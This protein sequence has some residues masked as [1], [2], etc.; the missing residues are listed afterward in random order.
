MTDQIE[1]VAAPMTMGGVKFSPSIAKLSTALAVAQ[2][3]ME[4]AKRDSNNPYFKSTYADLASA[5]EAVRK[6][7]SDNELSVIQLPQSEGSTVKVVSVLAHSSGEWVSSELQIEAKD[8]GAQSVGSAITYARRYS[9]MAICG[10]APDDDDGNASTHTSPAKKTLERKQPIRDQSRK[11]ESDTAREIET[12]FT[13]EPD[14]EV[15]GKRVALFLANVC[16]AKTKEDYTTILRY[17]TSNDQLS[18]DA[19]K[20]NAEIMSKVQVQV[21]DACQ[22]RGVRPS[23]LLASLKSEP[24]SELAG[25]L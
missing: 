22:V 19:A 10:I 8:S 16:G 4:A 6:P 11:E 14:G 3:Q 25:T 9:L 17:V 7:L 21:S 2:G 20:M 5:W 12:H 23:E 15:I 1:T 24:V 18:W 13:G